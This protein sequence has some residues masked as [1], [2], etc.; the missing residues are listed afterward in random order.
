MRGPQQHCPKQKGSRRNELYEC[1]VFSQVRLKTQ[2]VGPQDDKGQYP[3]S[4][5]SLR[6]VLKRWSKQAVNPEY[7][8]ARESG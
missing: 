6:G 1:L 2:V 4:V 5:E 3:E 7:E 8:K